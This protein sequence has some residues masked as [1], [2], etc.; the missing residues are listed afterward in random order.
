MSTMV[1][2]SIRI[3]EKK[4]F[5]TKFNGLCTVHSYINAVPVLTKG[6]HKNK[7]NNSII[8]NLTRL[9]YLLSF[10]LSAEIMCSYVLQHVT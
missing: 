6:P 9:M 1:H 8:L 5:I 4:H 3:K 2:L 7:S 10:L